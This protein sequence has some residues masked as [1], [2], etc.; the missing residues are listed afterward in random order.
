MG[1]ENQGLAMFLGVIGL[2]FF[3]LLIVAYI[4]GDV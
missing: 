2:L 1:T 4:V 3:V